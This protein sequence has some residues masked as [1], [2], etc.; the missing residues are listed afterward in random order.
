MNKAYVLDTTRDLVPEW[1]YHK[2]FPLEKVRDLL[3]EGKI[4]FE[5]I[6]GAFKE[7]VEFWL[8]PE[9]KTKVR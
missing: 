9:I 7:G 5:E 2:D 6:A 3:S 8:S 1:L 4:T